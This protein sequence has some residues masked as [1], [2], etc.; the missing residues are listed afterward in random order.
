M[1]LG[2]LFSNPTI[3]LNCHASPVPETEESEPGQTARYGF[4]LECFIL[5][6]APQN[7][8]DPAPEGGSSHGAAVVSSK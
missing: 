7:N 1:V 8:N 6:K 4:T 5:R 3:A 2:G